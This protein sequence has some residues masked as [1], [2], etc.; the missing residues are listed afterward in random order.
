MSSERQYNGWLDPRTIREVENTRSYDN[1]KPTRKSRAAF[2]AAPVAKETTA[3]TT[4][5]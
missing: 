3:T 2:H 4:E 1:K 5:V